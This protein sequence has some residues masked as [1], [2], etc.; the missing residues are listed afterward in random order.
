MIKWLLKGLCIV[1][2]TLLPISFSSAVNVYKS[3]WE[4]DNIWWNDCTITEDLNFHCSVSDNV[5]VWTDSSWYKSSSSYFWTNSWL[6][7]YIYLENWNS[8]QWLI[9]SFV[10]CG[11]DNVW[12]CN[13]H[14]SYE[15]FYI[16]AQ[17]YQLTQWRWY[18]NSSTPW[19]AG[20]DFVFWNTHI[21][22]WP[23]YVS[24]WN[25]I[26]VWS[27]YPVVYW[28]HWYWLSADYSSA[29]NSPFYNNN[30]IIEVPVSNWLTWY[31]YVVIT[32]QD[33]VDYFESEYNFRKDMCYVWTK[34]LTWLYEDRVVYHQWTW[35]TIFDTYSKL[36]NTDSIKISELWTF[37]NMWKLNYWEWFVEQWNSFVAYYSWV[38]DYWFNR[39]WTLSNPFLWNRAVYFF[40]GWDFYD[41]NVNV[42]NSDGNIYNLALYCY[43][44]LND[45]SNDGAVF[46]ITD[47]HDSVV[48]EWVAVYS[49]NKRNSWFYFSGSSEIV[50]QSWQWTPLDYFTWVDENV[51]FWT[52]F[53]DSFTRFKNI[54]VWLDFSDLFTWQLPSYIL[55]FFMAIIF[56]RFLGH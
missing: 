45:K 46:N 50:W 14:I 56:F 2:L 48:D 28:L 42:I 24:N 27:Y 37:L 20:I 52:F 35:Y 12:S 15:D 30:P 7:M 43:H 21:Y 6:A 9:T 38:W 25:L 1:W 54:F 22:F 29:I 17:S 33:Y 23:D 36:F 40:I 13:T 3:P 41:Y 55:M 53:S 32:W 26:T 5:I 16:Y 31:N 8:Y 47:D 4:Y 19:W 44:K 39:W 51:D 18:S 11:S 49:R 34:D 10:I